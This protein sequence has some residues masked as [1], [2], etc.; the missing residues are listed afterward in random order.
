MDQ[1]MHATVLLKE[2]VDLLSV[3]PGGIYVDATLG[4]GGHSEEILSRLT[5]G[6]LYAFDRDDYAIARASSRLSRFANIT[7]VKSDFAHLAEELE[8]RGIT[9][10]DGIVY[11]LGVSSF[12]F[13]MPDRGFS[14]RND[15]PL[16]MRMDRDASLSARDIVNGWSAAD[17]AD[18]LFR[19]GEESFA[20]PIANAIVAA[21]KTKAIETTGELVDI[22]RSVLP[23]KILAKKGHPAKQAF[24]ALRIAVNDELGQLSASLQQAVGLLNPG[25]RIAVITFQSLEDRIV[26]RYF[27]SLAVIEVPKGLPVMTT[28]KPL[29][30][31]VNE[32]VLIPSEA[33][34]SANNRA[35]GAKLRVAEK[36]VRAVS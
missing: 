32:H 5:Y 10:I 25:G 33:E 14:Y 35:K 18:I 16:D 34:I 28:E 1:Y 19:Y 24:Q 11:D 7:Y 9:A 4:G 30:R 12:Q 2:T 36:N 26:K 31:L 8:A 17:L 27:R 29:L 23:A 6:R 15:A 13:D 22:I 3:R 20:R 21:R